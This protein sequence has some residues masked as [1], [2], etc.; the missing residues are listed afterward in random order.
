[1]RVVVLGA[2]LLLVSA[3]SGPH[4][5]GDRVEV[6]DGYW[7]M[8]ARS[9]DDPGCTAAERAALL[10]IGDPDGKTV[11]AVW[12]GQ[13]TE[14]YVDELGYTQ[15]RTTSGAVGI[16]F[17]VEILDMQDGSRRI[18]PISCSYESGAPAADHWND[19]GPDGMEHGYNGVGN[20]PWLHGPLD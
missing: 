19:C 1:M 3:C 2:L 4:W 16:D 12:D 13:W 7:V 15:M 10:A 6:V 18:V 5:V 20:E 9:C 11:A 8:G 17:F 14:A